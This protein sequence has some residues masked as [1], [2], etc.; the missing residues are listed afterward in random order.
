M[1][2]TPRNPLI[3]GTHVTVGGHALVI[4]SLNFRQLKQFNDQLV[5]FRSVSADSAYDDLT[6]VIPVIH[7]AISRNYPS[8]TLEDLEDLVDLGNYRSIIEAV[9]AVSGIT[10]D[11]T[12]TGAVAPGESQPVPRTSPV[13]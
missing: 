9:M 10:D 7:A 11:T 5:R 13:Q 1:D 2:T 3:P 4:P 12:R 8:I 6:S